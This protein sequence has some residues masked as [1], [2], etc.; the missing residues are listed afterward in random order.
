MQA[1]YPNLT[2]SNV[3][4]LI[5]ST[6]ETEVRK[7]L[8]SFKLLDLDRNNIIRHQNVINVRGN[9]PR[10]IGLKN[11]QNL[12]SGINPFANFIHKNGHKVKTLETNLTLPNENWSE[13]LEYFSKSFPNLTYLKV[14]VAFDS[15]DSSISDT[16]IYAV[17]HPPKTYLF[18]K[19]RKLDIY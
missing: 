8:L 13:N 14:F 16:T 12:S 6:W 11:V 19:V 4:T 10:S 1:F 7:R 5:N 18:W 17:S 3:C 9:C 15:T 2:S